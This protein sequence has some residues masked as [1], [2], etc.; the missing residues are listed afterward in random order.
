MA[1]QPLLVI[2]AV[3]VV[4]LL[5]VVFVVTTQMSASYTKKVGCVDSV[6]I[7]YEA[8]TFTNGSQASVTATTVTSFNTTLG[9]GFLVLR[10][11]N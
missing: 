8:S 9:L 7:V 10:S 11:M 5:A 3:I 4:S 2:I 6:V 1:R